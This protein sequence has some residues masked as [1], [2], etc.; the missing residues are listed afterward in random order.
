MDSLTRLTKKQVERVLYRKGD[1]AKWNADG[2]HAEHAP[3][4]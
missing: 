1:G 4:S 3:A 2:E